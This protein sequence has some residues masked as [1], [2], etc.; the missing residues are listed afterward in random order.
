MQT[1]QGETTGTSSSARIGKAL[2]LHGS[3]RPAEGLAGSVETCDLV[4]EIARRIHAS[5]AG[6]G[7]SVL[8]SDDVLLDRLRDLVRE[9]PKSFSQE[10]LRRRFD[11][12]MDAEAARLHLTHGTWGRVRLAGCGIRSI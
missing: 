12:E 5:H 2:N 6:S 1:T 10:D 4:A 8:A 3:G 7:A 11:A 9:M